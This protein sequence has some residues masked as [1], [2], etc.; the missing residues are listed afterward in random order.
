MKHLNKILIA[1]AIMMGL[2]ATAQD[3]KNKWAVSFGVN[4]LDTKTSAGGGNNWLDGHLSQ[5][6]SVKDNWNV[7][8]AI[9]YVGVSRYLGDNFSVGISGSINKLSKYV[10][11]SKGDYSVSNPGDLKYFGIDATVKYSLKS[12]I[13]SEKLE[14]SITLGLGYSTLGDNS[15]QTISPGVGVVYWATKTVG[16]EYSSKYVKSYEAREINNVVNAPSMLQHSLGL[17]VKFAE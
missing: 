12:A 1:F 17:V 13:K 16:F 7:L 15:Y 10:V 4:A 14:P 9:S 3:S 5:A 2:N 11:A 6:F 8:P